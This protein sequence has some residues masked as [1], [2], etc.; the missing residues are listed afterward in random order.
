MS[1]AAFWV[2]QIG[3]GFFI[4]NCVLQYCRDMKTPLFFVMIFDSSVNFK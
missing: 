1:S 3:Y 2:I 4:G